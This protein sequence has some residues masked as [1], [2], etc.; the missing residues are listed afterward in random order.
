GGG[1]G[2]E[3][4]H[5]RARRQD[6]QDVTRKRGEGAVAGADAGRG[7]EAH[8]CGRARDRFRGA[9]GALPR[10]G[11]GHGA[12]RCAARPGAARVCGRRQAQRHARAAA[13]EREQ[14]VPEPRALPVSVPGTEIGTRGGTRDGTRD[15]PSGV[16]GL[17]GKL[18]ARGDFLSR[19]L[20]AEFIAGWDEWLQRTMRDSRET[21]GERW[22]ECFLSA[23]VWRF[24]LPA[25]MYSKPGWVG[26]MLPSVD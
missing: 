25:G 17:Y 13:D 6:E 7:H 14:P 16:A 19:R 1:V 11:Q 26:I 5:V 4:G 3:R 24:V 12:A 9:V 18:P 20:D 22:L 10:A 21:L 2:R 8:R 23:P 15:A